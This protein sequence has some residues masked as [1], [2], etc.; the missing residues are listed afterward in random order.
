MRDPDGH[1]LYRAQEIR[2]DAEDEQRRAAQRETERPVC[3]RCGRKLTD[4]R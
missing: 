4:E 2:A 1:A 3:K